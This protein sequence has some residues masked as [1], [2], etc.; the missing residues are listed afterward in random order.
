MM[1][2]N[3]RAKARIKKQKEEKHFAAQKSVMAQDI[4]KR[5][6]VSYTLL[7]KCHVNVYSKQLPFQ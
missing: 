1:F 6:R 5:L 3:F 2:D 4:Q 7:Y